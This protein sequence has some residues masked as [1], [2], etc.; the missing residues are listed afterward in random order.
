ML[1]MDMEII[2]SD[3]LVI[4]SGIAGLRAALE[5]SKRGKRALL[6]SKAP[7]GKANNT[8]LA[9]GVFA[10]PP[11][12]EH[13]D[14]HIEKILRNG[15]NLNM[16]ALVDICAR[17][18]S[19]LVKELQEMGMRGTSQGTVFS[20]RSV[21]L[22]GGPEV[23]S[24]LLRACRKAGVNF[25]E[26]IM[27]TDL[28]INGEICNGA[29]GFQKHTGELYGFPA[30][31]VVLATGGAG[32]IYAQNDNA[33]GITGDGYALGMEA[34]LELIDMEFVQFF[35]LVYAGSGPVRMIVPSVLAD[36]GTLT[37]R[38]GEDLKK[39]YGLTERHVAVVSR[40]RLAQALF[41]EITQGNGIDGA[42]LLDIRHVE[43]TKIPLSN[44]V[45]ELCKRRFSY[46]STPLRIAPACHYTMGGLVIDSSGC[47]AI[48][49]LYA[50]G[51]VVG[52]ID[53][54]NRVGG[55]ALSS[56]L[57]FGALG[58]R[59]ALASASTNPSLSDFKA[60]AHRAAKRRFSIMTADHPHTG[61]VRVLM[62]RLQRVL[63]EKVGILRSDRSLKEGI[64]AI[65]E[66]LVKLPE[67][68]AANPRELCRILEAR[69]AAL[70]G[71][72]IAVSALA[73][74]E[75]RGAHYRSDFPEEDK[76]WLKRISVQLKYG[77]PNVSRI[78]PAGE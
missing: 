44:E 1:E 36:L 3:V 37:N 61:S 39:K 13:L 50:A 33:P 73:R 26:R 74:T 7:I 64:K 60:M 63:W 15:R 51:E 29:I 41:T 27:I 75:S 4:G 11:E 77:P 28:I 72:A 35:P 18:A 12:P 22:T 16:R 24:T 57:V 53:G 65:D 66:I 47:T 10:F 62:K 49:G 5:I 23:T 58:A 32:A 21:A 48:K 14:A 55:N 2:A 30:G 38:F 68:R 67:Y 70:T 34:G 43:E 25:L 59:S 17:Q 76:N 69:N 19:S 31:A 20:T 52:G 9:G 71:R 8:Y 45:R 6:V 40:D 46:G 56:S 54:A 78:L 42:L